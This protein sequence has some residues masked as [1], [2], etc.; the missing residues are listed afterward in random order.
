MRRWG[1]WTACWLHPTAARTSSRAL[2]ALLLAVL[3]ASALAWTPV[4]AQAP[5]PA[6]SGDPGQERERVASLPEVPVGEHDPLAPAHGWPIWLK[7]FETRRRTD[8][9]AGI[10]Y[11]GRDASGRRCFFLAD[12]VGVLHL[13]RVEQPGDTGR[14]HLTLEPVGFE[15]GALEALADL[16]RWDFSALALR[17]GGRGAQAG[18]GSA[19]SDTLSGLLAIAG[20]GPQFAAQT[21]L[22][23]V[24]FLRTGGEA[25]AQVEWRMAV[26]G[27]WLPGANF[28]EPFVFPGEGLAG[29]GLA[30][31]A[32]YLGLARLV[33]QGEFNVRGTMLFVYDQE[34]AQV[35]R[36]L[37]RR[38]GIRSIGGLHALADS[39]IVL[40][41]RDR[42]AVNV[43]RWDTQ[44]SGQV[45]ACDRF[46]LELTAPGGFRFGIPAVEGLTIDDRGDLW[47]VVSPDP[48]QYRPLDTAAPE[49]LHVYMAAGM[50]I[51]YRFPG[52]RLW[53]ETGLE[54]LWQA[55]QR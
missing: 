25:P 50:P 52:D 48:R 7:D 30:E 44:G 51:L 54:E 5:T 14:V 33:A 47:C 53:E 43:L 17:P 26:E 28:W 24:R 2:P 55:K 8:R 13:C 12:A 11:A 32:T 37:T 39:V 3:I 23:A 27:P 20:R 29:V 16:E 46:P 9:T 18:A 31:R 6:P 41:D 38:L 19:L 35:A 49:T 34:R 42:Q 45:V 15:R 21:R 36:I 10:A 1:C 4:E 22:L 40:A